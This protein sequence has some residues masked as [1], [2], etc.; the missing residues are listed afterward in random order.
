M[1]KF[2]T[3]T[4]GIALGFT[5]AF[6]LLYFPGCTAE[7]AVT[8]L[9]PDGAADN[10]LDTKIVDAKDAFSDY[11]EA[12]IAN[13]GG[14]TLG[15]LAG[16]FINK[17]GTKKKS[18]KIAEKAFD[19]GVVAGKNEVAQRFDVTTTLGKKQDDRDDS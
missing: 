15:G 2:T 9:N 4:I 10:L 17:P 14:L 13:A 7:Q 18:E 19:A 1:S 3:Y 5:A 16:L 12:L 6:A 8:L 11:F